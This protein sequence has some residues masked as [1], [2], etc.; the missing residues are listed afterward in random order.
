MR[1]KVLTVSDNMDATI[2]L[3]NSLN[4]NNWDYHVIDTPFRGFGT[5]LISV[6]KYLKSNPDIKEL[7]F[8]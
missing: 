5:K 8:L 1:I 3:I 6:Y 7:Y 4:K 2:P